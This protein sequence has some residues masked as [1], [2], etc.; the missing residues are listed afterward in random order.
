M[1]NYRVKCCFSVLRP[2]PLLKEL[3]YVG[4]LSPLRSL[5]P[6]DLNWY[7]DSTAHCHRNLLGRDWVSPEESL[8]VV[9]PRPVRPGPGNLP[10]RDLNGNWGRRTYPTARGGIK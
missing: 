3:W 9:E 4:P 10:D 8:P 7:R 5:E 2:L 1:H 6:R